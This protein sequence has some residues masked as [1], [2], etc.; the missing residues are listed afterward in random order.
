MQKKITNIA[1]YMIVTIL[2]FSCT[3][4]SEAYAAGKTVL[5]EI[6]GPI[7]PAA[8]DYIERGITHANEEK[9]AAVII[10]L[11]TPGGL[12]TSMRGINAAILTSSVPV[13]TYVAPTGA[14]AASAGIFIM[15]ASHLAVMAPG[16]NAG[17]A[18]PVNL[19]GSN[20]NDKKQI[21]TEA[22]KSMNDA[23]AYIRS[24]AQLRD[25]NAAWAE[26]AVTQAASVS[27]NE[28]K[29]INVINDIAS[30]I[31]Q[32]LQ[33]AN[34]KSVSINNKSTIINTNNTVIEKVG[35]DWRHDFLTFITNP[36]IAYLLIL[37]AMYGLFFELSNPGLILPGVAGIIALLLALYAMQLLPV[38]Y[39]GLS[40]ILVGITFI[41]ME[42]YITSYG[43][44]GIGGVIAFVIGSVMLFDTTDIHFQV[45]WSLI[46]TMSLLTT[47]FFFVI[48]TM[49]IRAHK[50]AIITGRE[51]IIG[52]DGV[53]I[54]VN[55]EQIIVRV[56]GELWEAKGN[57]SIQPGDKV[58]VT[59]IKGLILHI[60][61]NTHSH[62]ARR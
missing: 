1:K 29:K 11:N 60:E 50:R 56:L 23:S 34:G 7:G 57:K 62:A 51:G 2:L 39:A 58:K 40:L 46:G 37:L 22:K 20:D 49:V 24:L 16:T 31:P 3:L 59:S 32:L 5:L 52:H 13:I 25:R 19:M 61:P 35:T 14:R 36:N 15:Y 26:L 53:V 45:S 38:N 12:E 44:L 33:Q 21:S 4:L 6:N 30:D 18:S 41:V 8:Q 55:N 28:A 48:A 17:A 42:V 9:A 43:A 54:T 10:Q 47:A 27:A